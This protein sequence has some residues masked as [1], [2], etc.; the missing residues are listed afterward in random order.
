[1]EDMMALANA[2]DQAAGADTSGQQTFDEDLFGRMSEIEH[3]NSA[4]ARIDDIEQN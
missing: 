3:R 1:M 4:I 2:I